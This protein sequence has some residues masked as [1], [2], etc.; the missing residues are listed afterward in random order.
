MLLRTKMAAIL[1]EED[2]S[3]EYFSFPKELSAERYVE[4]THE[5][6]DTTLLLFAPVGAARGKVLIF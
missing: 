5:V 4:L 6:L 2:V 1:A 3:E